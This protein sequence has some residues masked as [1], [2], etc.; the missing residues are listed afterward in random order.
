[1]VY[2]ISSLPT[3][4]HSHLSSSCYVD[5]CTCSN[6]IENET[7]HWNTQMDLLVETYLDYRYRDLGDGMP[8]IDGMP[9]SPSDHD[10]CIP[11]H[12]YPNETLIYHGY[13]ECAPLY[14]TVTISLRTLAAYCQT[15][16]VCSTFSFQA[17]CKTLCFLHDVS[18]LLVYHCVDQHLCTA[19]KC[20][21]PNWCLLNACPTCFYKLEDEPNFDFEWLTSMDGNNSLKRWDSMIYGTNVRL[22]SHKVQS[23]FWID[24]N[25]VDKFSGEVRVH[26]VSI[27]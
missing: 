17:Q 22:N 16:R 4:W 27:E 10:V 19:L 3:V 12:Q 23:D 25:T 20:D 5:P 11:Y 1:M 24:P 15:H 21:T 14:P 13:V 9:P 18:I 26:A 7:N 2:V 6:H 8:H